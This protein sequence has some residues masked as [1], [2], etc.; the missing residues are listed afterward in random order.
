ML[1]PNRVKGHTYCLW[2]QADP[3]D[4]FRES[5]EADNFSVRAIRITRNNNVH[6]LSTN[7]RCT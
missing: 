1:L 2:Q 4:L 7:S 3:R 6:Y 5:N